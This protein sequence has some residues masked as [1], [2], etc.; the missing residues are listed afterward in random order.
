[1]NHFQA[2]DHQ[3]DFFHMGSGEHEPFH[4]QGYIDNDVYQEPPH[5]PYIEN[6]THPNAPPVMSQGPNDVPNNNWPDQ[7]EGVHPAFI[8]APIRY[9][10]PHP[11]EGN[12]PEMRSFPFPGGWSVPWQQGFPFPDGQNFPGQ[13]GTFPGG[14]NFPGQQAGPP[15]TPPPAFTPQMNQFQT[16]AIDPGAIRNCL[17]RFTYIWLRRDAFWFYPVFLGRNSIAGFRWRWNR[18]VYFGIDLDRIESFQCF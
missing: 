7:H 1:M 11:S 8:D 13:Q 14:G 18:W 15:T 12:V 5:R 9:G 3:N 2:Q 16:F 10:P 4:P 6:I 17:F